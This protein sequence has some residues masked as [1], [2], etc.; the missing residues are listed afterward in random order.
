MSPRLTAYAGLMRLNRPWPILLILCP[1]LWGLYSGPMLPTP[2]E[3]LIFIIGVFLTRSAGCVINDYFDRKIDGQVTR[4]KTRP[5]QRGVIQ[6]KEAVLLFLALMFIAL[7]LLLFLKRSVMLLGVGAFFLAL[8][9]PLAKRFTYFPQMVLGIAFNFGLLMAALQVNDTIT[10]TAW[11]YYAFAI[12]WTIHYDTLY[13]L[14][15]YRDDLRIGVKSI[16][17]FFKARVYLFLGFTSMLCW[18]FVASIWWMTGLSS[19][20]IFI[21]MMLGLFFVFQ[22]W[23]LLVLHEEASLPLFKQHVWVGML[24]FLGVLY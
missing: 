15:D 10:R 4:T 14:S 21:L 16:A 20:R 2:R 18:G 6:A 8:F 5:L 9:Y 3:V 7:L 23:R 24:I 12:L 11:A 17:T 13:A 22:F 1:T 19:L